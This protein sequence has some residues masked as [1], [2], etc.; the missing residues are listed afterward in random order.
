MKEAVLSD[1]EEAVIIV[2][3]VLEDH[4]HKVDTDIITTARSRGLVRII[5]LL[6]IDY[7]DTTDQQK[8]SLIQAVSDRTASIQGKIRYFILL[9]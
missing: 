4:D 3:K 6:D 7:Q 5:K 8:Q 1:S 2:K 9:L